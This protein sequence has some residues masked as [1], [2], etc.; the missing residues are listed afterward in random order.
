VDCDHAILQA[1]LAILAEDGYGALTMAGVA[2]RSGVSTA[3]LYRRWASKEDLV[4]GALEGM[5]DPRARAVP[6]TGSLRGDLT[7]LL[8]QMAD[9]LTERGGRIME[10]LLSETLRNKELART[11]RRRLTEPRQAELAGILHRAV[12]R[13][14]IPP[15]ADVGVALSLITGPI[16]QRLLITGEPVNRRLVHDL[17]DLLLRAFG[18]H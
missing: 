14:E 12:Q 8:T 6:D 2:K 9:V 17:V 5:T 7:Q 15:V 18:A 16:Y 10:G 3:T 1:T 11:L 13:E 4:I